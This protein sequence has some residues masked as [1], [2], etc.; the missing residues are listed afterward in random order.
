MDLQDAAQKANEHFSW[1]ESYVAN[2]MGAKLRS[3][4]D[5][6]D[7][8]QSALKS[9]L[10]LSV[11]RW[12]LRHSGLRCQQSIDAPARIAID[13]AFNPAQKQSRPRKQRQGKRDLPND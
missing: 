4:F 6:K 5:A 13:E 3:R 10:K 2:R 7:V 9:F 11:E 8:V 1:L 12:L